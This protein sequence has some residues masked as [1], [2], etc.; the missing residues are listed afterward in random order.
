MCFHFSLSLAAF[1][2]WIKLRA[3]MQ[4]DV[5]YLYYFVQFILCFVNVWTGF[6]FLIQL[7]SI[8]FWSHFPF[9]STSIAMTS[10]QIIMG[11]VC[12]FFLFC[13]YSNLVLLKMYI[14]IEL[15]SLIT[16]CKSCLQVNI[17]AIFS[18]ISIQVVWIRIEKGG[19]RLSTK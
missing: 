7:S 1:C 19:K 8:W 2:R 11:K 18:S 4:M 13:E 3:I 17:F 14:F 10:N 5:I 15:N 6:F 9:T 16:L 12:I